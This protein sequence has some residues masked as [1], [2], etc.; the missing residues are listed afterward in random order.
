MLVEHL[1]EPQALV[2]LAESSRNC[3][4][5]TREFS[6]PSPRVVSNFP[7]FRK[8][9]SVAF[10]AQDADVGDMEKRRLDELIQFVNE[11]VKVDRVAPFDGAIDYR[12]NM[13]SAA[14]QCPVDCILLASTENVPVGI[15]KVLSI[16]HFEQGIT[17][18]TNQQLVPKVAQRMVQAIGNTLRLSTRITF[19]DPYFNDRQKMWDPMLAFIDAAVTESPNSSKSIEILFDGSKGRA[20]TAEYLLNKME[21]EQANLISRLSSLSFKDIRELDNGEALHNRY[22]ITELGAV[23][24]GI[25]LDERSEHEQ[26][27]VFMLNDELYQRRYSQYVELQGFEL[28]E[29]Q[30]TAPS[31]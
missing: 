15:D 18:L 11:Q 5:F 4:D 7:K 25:G 20:C 9:K 1:I 27:D 13:I 26:D 10:C 28:Y 21:R 24:F 3:R 31:E 8:L 22:V 23:S 6:K 30:C 29:A 12:D 14:R 19:V 2:K 17:P 16:E